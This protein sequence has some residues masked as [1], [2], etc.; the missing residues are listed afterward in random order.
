MRID[1]IAYRVPDRD[2]T[3]K[4][5]VEAFGYRI[6]DEFCIDFEDGTSAKCYALSPPERYSKTDFAPPDWAS[7][8]KISE[9]HVPPEIF[10]SQGTEASVVQE[11]VQKRDNVGGIHHIAYQVEDVH[12]IMKEWTE[13]GWAEFTTDEPIVAEGI[14]QCFTKPHPLTGIIYEFIYRTNKGFN[15]N[16]V[17][18]L[19]ESTEGL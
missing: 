4:F 11:W 18:D 9:Y 13:K 12:A 1:H 5:F 8:G 15:I 7:L 19:M 14:V 10:V 17:R 2:A 16:N 6:E 3:A